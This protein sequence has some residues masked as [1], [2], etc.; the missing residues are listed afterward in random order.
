L[1][2]LTAD[3]IEKFSVWSLIA[4]ILFGAIGLWIFNEGRKRPNLIWIVIGI[5]MMVYP[6]FVSAPLPS[7]GIGFGL[8]F[9]AH[10]TKNS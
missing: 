5:A 9:A 8:C 7:W 2:N 4:G 6:L 3:L 10:Q 1:S